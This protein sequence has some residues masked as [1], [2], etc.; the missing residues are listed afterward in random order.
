MSRDPRL[1]PEPGD[2]WRTAW[3]VST[4]ESVS[5]AGGVKMSDGETYT[6]EDFRWHTAPGRWAVVPGPERAA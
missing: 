6:R 2:R 3:G 4:V 5:A 1:N